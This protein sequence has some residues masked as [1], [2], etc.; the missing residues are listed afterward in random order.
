[1]YVDEADADSIVHKL[2]QLKYVRAID[3][4]PY[5]FLKKRMRKK[6]MKC[7]KK[8]SFIVKVESNVGVVRH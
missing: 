5:K 1:M 2:M 7:F 8:I 3:G 6:N 4:S